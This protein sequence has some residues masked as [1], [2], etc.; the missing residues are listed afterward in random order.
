MF[1]Q[2]VEYALRAVVHLALDPDTPQ[3]T[4]DVAERTQ[5][6]AGYLSKVLQALGRADL[7]ASQR[8]LHGGF[9]L[10]RQPATIT[11]LDVINAVDPLHRIHTCPLGIKSHGKNLCPLHRKLDDALAAIEKT[12]A[13]TTM[14]DLIEDPKANTPLCEIKVSARR[15]E[16]KSAPR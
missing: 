10:S 16:K 9:T 3:T 7:V 4:Q 12:F 5:V 15:K 2:T 13:D 8:G 11:L 14:A 1:S 6:P